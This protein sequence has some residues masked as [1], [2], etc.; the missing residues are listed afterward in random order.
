M[1]QEVTVHE[2]DVPSLRAWLMVV[3][4]LVGIST[5]PAAFGIGSIGVFIGPLQERFGWGRAE[6]SSAISL[7]MLC[8][9]LCVPLAGALVDRL[10]PRRVLAPSLVVLGLCMAA[11]PHVRELWQFQAVY[12]AMGTL[13]AGSNSVAYMRILA[14]WFDKSRGLAIGIAG[15]GTGLGFAYV[16]VF[17]EYLKS[18]YGWAAGYYGLAALAVFVTLPM[19]L[20]FLKERDGAE[21]DA[22]SPT[23]A[24]VTLAEALRGR[25]FWVL[26]AMFMGVSAVLY[27]LL[28]HLVPLLT[29]RGLDAGRAAAVASIFGLATFG[30]RILI[31]FLVD[32][33]DARRI[34]LI[35]FMLS[36]LGIPMLGADLPI[37]AVFVAAFLLGGSLGAEVDMLAYL[38]SRYFGLR[39]F[40]RIFG[41]LFGAVMLAMGAGPVIF[42]AIYDATG[43]YN[44][45][46]YA[47]A[48]LCA[49][50]ALV[51]LAL[52]PYGQRRRGGPVSVT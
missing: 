6:L 46:L 17:T 20:L 12:V 3:V 40:A 7:L 37:W 8:T 9:A 39:C 14:S 2:R 52:R 13:A 5:G 21:V 47:G 33:F 22:A 41:V 31:G 45:M 30:G 23:M 29:G 42:G 11:A 25:D 16:P 48:P 28:P 4:C 36:A 43:S 1:S 24:G 27:G 44:L 26:A 49:V 15:S 38:T 34:A 10:G 18:H 51:T 35:F 50:A 32:R 19:V